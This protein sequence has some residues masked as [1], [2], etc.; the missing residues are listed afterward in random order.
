MQDVLDRFDKY[1]IPLDTQVADIDHFDQRKD[2]TIDQ[3]NWAGLPAYF[4]K[5][6][7]QGMKTVLLLDP[8]LVVNDTSY[9][10]FTTGLQNKVF[11]EWPKGKS[12]DFNEY[13]NDIMLGYV[14]ILKILNS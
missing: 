7:E 1:E 8:G 12:P 14:R 11:I 3:K 2:F 5:L 13:K 9:W 4:D 10:P 6:H